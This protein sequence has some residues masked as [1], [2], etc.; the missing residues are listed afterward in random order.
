[1]TLLLVPLLQC[2][3]P[4]DLTAD[5][6]T[7]S[8]FWSF[9]VIPALAAQYVRQSVKDSPLDNRLAPVEIDEYH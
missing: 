9:K 4:S 3:D 8:L 5:G 1:M 2:L 6:L 7:R